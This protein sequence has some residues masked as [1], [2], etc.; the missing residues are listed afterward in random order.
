V[1]TTPPSMTTSQKLAALDY[2]DRRQEVADRLRYQIDFLQTVF[3]TLSLMNG[4]S[5]VALFTLLGTGKVP[6]AMTYIWWAFG[7]FAIGLLFNIVAVVFA[8]LSQFHYKTGAIRAAVNA[9]HEMH[10]Q[11][12]PHEL[13]AHW[14]D[15]DTYLALSLAA[16]GLSLIGFLGGA[17]LSFLAATHV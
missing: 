5:I 9:R 13:T 2:D 12:P 3:R 11:T 16:I 15:A 8:F 14:E 1:T 7:G 10:C 4:G 6:F 17:A